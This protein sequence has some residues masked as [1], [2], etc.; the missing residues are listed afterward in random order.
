MCN[1]EGGRAVGNSNYIDGAVSHSVWKLHKKVAVNIAS[2]ASYVYIWSGQKLVKNAK[3]GFWKP[4][5][6]GQ[7]VLPESSL[8][9]GQKLSENDKIKQFK[10]DNGNSKYVR[11]WDTVFYSF[12]NVVDI[13]HGVPLCRRPA[14]VRLC[15]IIWDDNHR[16]NVSRSP[17]SHIF[18]SLLIDF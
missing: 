16:G 8:L 12:L 10:C 13:I 1:R 15:I 4:K 14:A 9:K 7:I 6:C 17:A 2:V 5:A 3:N 18:M 11:F